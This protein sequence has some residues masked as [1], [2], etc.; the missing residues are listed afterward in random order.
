M[1]KL[2]SLLLIVLLASSVALA[3]EKKP[4]ASGDFWQ[5]LIKKIEDIKPNKSGPPTTAVGGVRGS[6]SS[7]AADTLYWKGEEVPVDVSAGELEKFRA[8]LSLAADGQKEEA[9]FFFGE[10]LDAYPQSVLRGDVLL[11][12][13]RLSGQP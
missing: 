9:L 6:N 1:K 10:F 7:S 2:L 11:A 3:E 8:A 12:Q 5:K 4:E 13:K